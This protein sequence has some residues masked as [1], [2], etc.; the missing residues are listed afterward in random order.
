MGVAELLIAVGAIAVVLLVVYFAG[1]SR[2]KL[3]GEVA[4][5]READAKGKPRG[6][7]NDDA[8]R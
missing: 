7:A 3:E 1:R 2:G 4:A 8:P 5:R 6:E